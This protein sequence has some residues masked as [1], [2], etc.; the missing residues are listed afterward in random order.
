MNIRLE[1]FG[2]PEISINGK[3]LNW[4]SKKSHALFIY[5][6]IMKKIPKNSLADI[7]WGDHHT[8]SKAQQS[9]RNCIYTIKKHFNTDLIIQDQ[10]NNLLLNKNHNYSSDYDDLL[11]NLLDVSTMQSLIFLDNYTLRKSTLFN[12]WLLTIQ[13]EIRLKL[14]DTLTENI[15]NK[16]NN[17]ELEAAEIFALKVL[18]LD[19]YDESAYLSLIKIYDMTG[20]FT[21]ISKL[22][23]DLERLYRE[24]LGI[25]PSQEIRSIVSEARENK[26]TLSK[27]NTSHISPDFVCRLKEMNTIEREIDL[28]L[29][30][31]N[32]NSL[33]ISGDVGVGKS[34]LLNEIK[35]E[36]LTSNQMYHSC[37]YRAEKSFILKPWHQII[38]SLTTTFKDRFDSFS[39]NM[40][41]PIISV[42]PFLRTEHIIMETEIDNIIFNNYE[43]LEREVV[44]MLD[45]ILEEEKIIITIDDVQWIDDVS[46]SL[47]RSILTHSKNIM[48]ILTSRTPLTSD[49]DILVFD[50][51]KQLTLKHVKLNTFS[52]IEISAMIQG[53]YPKL[54]LSEPE[55]DRLYKSSGGNP[56]FLREML[57]NFITTGSIDIITDNIKKLLQQRIYGLSRD[58]KKILEL[59]SIHFDGISLDFFISMSLYDEIKLVNLLENLL[60]KSFITESTELESIKY[61]FKHIQMQ[62]CIYSGMS[63]AKRKILHNSTA[64]IFEEQ[65]RNSKKE[66]YYTTRIIYHYEKANNIDK[67]IEYSIKYLYNYLCVAHEFFPVVEINSKQVRIDSEHITQR[68]NKIASWVDAIDVTTISQAEAHQI[69]NFYHMLSRYYIRSGK[70]EEGLSY[71]YR[72]KDLSLESENYMENILKA[73]RQ[74]VCVFM[75]LYDHKSLYQVISEAYSLLT[76]INE[77][78]AIWKR[79]EGYYHLMTKDLENSRICLLEAIRIFE[80]SRNQHKYIVN[81]AAAY[82]WLGESYRF[83]HDYNIADQNYVKAISLCE[84]DDLLGGTPIFYA[85]YGQS[86]FEQDKL[87]LA[88]K[89]F[90]KSLELYEK[91]DS[92]WGRSISYGY[93]ALI[94]GM[95]NQLETAMDDIKNAVT[96]SDQLRSSYEI[97]LVDENIHTICHLI[98]KSSK[99]YLY[100]KK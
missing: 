5:I 80:S 3:S 55:Y 88:K 94:H 6:Y 81:L 93:R 13:E 9:L 39:K 4:P 44:F 20:E 32:Y 54:K 84:E 8:T 68:F 59:M 22:Y 57:N 74:L 64:T 19:E 51:I 35:N 27:S 38:Q 1:L 72:L 31:R 18:N 58:E 40:I 73:N 11:N 79:I 60:E 50:M 90:S 92:L 17:S 52:R 76:T 97:N 29:S 96:F 30:N 86:L 23:S 36:Y 66:S 69:S 89:T 10:N 49:L 62:E 85:N 47:I 87:T 53:L 12:E 61:H 33:L 65:L 100:L 91:T 71:I 99:L 95:N 42:F 45:R 7:L 46:L 77:E 24:E 82:N 2:Y 15:K 43:M 78:Y 26:N 25:A 41:T 67:Y 98:P 16:I 70:Y 63:F 75:N 48:F 21:K 56:Y 83:S 34:S 28:F 37:C 14:I